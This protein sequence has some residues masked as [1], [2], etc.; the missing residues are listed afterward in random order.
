M[1]KQ[2]TIRYF[3]V[4]Q[5][6]R[7]PEQ[8][9]ERSAGYYLYAADTVIILP[10]T[11][12]TYSLDLRLAIPAGFFGKIMPRSSILVDHLVTMDGGVIDSDF[13]GIVKAIL[14]N[15]SNKTFTVRVGDR[16]AQ[17]IILEK[18]NVKFEKVSDKNL[19]GGT[20]RG[21]NGFGSMGLRMIKKTKVD[22]W[23]INES[24]DSESP[25]SP[26]QQI[27]SESPESPKKSGEEQ[28]IVYEKATMDV[29]GKVIIDENVVRKYS[30]KIIID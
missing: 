9:T 16:I 18:Y 8:T 4:S 30:E 6:A 26:K 23:V 5:I 28:E 21:S 10:Q 24:N 13:R 17:I 25:E 27:V 15:L 3:E 29:N 1:A 11:A 20:K 2:V 7:E 19:L 14:V 12:Q 22:E